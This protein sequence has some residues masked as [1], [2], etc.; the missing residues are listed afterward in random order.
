MRRY[1][2][3]VDSN[4]DGTFFRN[5]QQHFLPQSL[6][7]LVDNVLQGSKIN[8]SNKQLTHSSL[9]I[10]QLLF[11]NSI[12]RIQQNIKTLNETHHSIELSST[13]GSKLQAH[14]NTVKIVCPPTL[15]S[16]VFIAAALDSIDHNPSSTTEKGPF[17]RTGISLFQHPAMK[18]PGVERDIGK[19][20]SVRRKLLQVRAVYANVSPISNLPL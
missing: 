14:Q 7:L 1:I 18:T 11:Q 15:K 12:K 13:L 9:T 8:S 3:L 19:T 17:H 6:Q 20:A 2:L 5:C 10:L 4:F 16:K